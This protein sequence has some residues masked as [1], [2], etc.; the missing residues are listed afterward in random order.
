MLGEA[1]VITGVFAGFRAMFATH[2]GPVFVDGA[3]IIRHQ[4]IAPTVDHDVPVFSV[5]IK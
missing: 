1:I 4:K 2:V 3:F 5:D